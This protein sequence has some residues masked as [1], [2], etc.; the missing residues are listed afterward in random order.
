MIKN[1]R[2]NTIDIVRGIAVILMVIA[3]SLVIFNGPTIRAFDLFSKGV[4]IVA[5][6]TFLFISG[7]ATYL[8]TIKPRLSNK[9]I[10]TKYIKLIK[11]LVVYYIVAFFI[12]LYYIDTCT[13]NSIV[14]TLIRVLLFIDIPSYT[15]FLPSLFIYAFLMILLRKY[16]KLLLKNNIILAITIVL[17][18]SVGFLLYKLDTP[19]ILTYYK[20]IFV[21]H[22]DWYRFPVI[23]YIPILFL[24]S[25]WSFEITKRRAIKLKV[26]NPINLNILTITLKF[27]IFILPI[28]LLIGILNYSNM[29]TFNLFNLHRWP[30]S[31]LFLLIGITFVISIIFILESIHKYKP[32]I[33]KFISKYIGFVGKIA[34]NIYFWHIIVL[35]SYR[36]FA[37]FYNYQ[38]M[39]NVLLVIV[40]VIIVFA[41]SIGLTI[42]FNLFSK[43]LNKQ[44]KKNSKIKQVIVA[45]VILLIAI[46]LPFL[47]S[48]IT[49]FNE[50]DL[51]I[52]NNE[53]PRE[54]KDWW[55]W[56]NNYRALT[57]MSVQNDDFWKISKGDYVK[58]TLNH[59]ALV[60]QNQSHISGRD[61][62]VVYYDGLKH[63]KLDTR[64]ENANTENTSI[65]FELANSI[66]TKNIDTNYYLYYSN[67]SASDTLQ[68]NTEKPNLSN[69]AYKI[70]LNEDI[71]ASFT[72]T[73]PRKWI[74]K[75]NSI[76][77]KNKQIIININVKNIT[78]SANNIF[79]LLQSEG[80]FY[81]F[82]PIEISPEQ[83]Q[84]IVNTDLLKSG[85]Y[86]IQSN[87]SGTVY[88]TTPIMVN[89]SYPLFVT[90]TIDFEGYSLKRSY[91]DSI[92]ELSNKYQM[93][94]TQFFN[95]R[96]FIANDV[97]KS[98]RKEMID[99]VNKREKE[100]GD[101]IA[102]HLHMHYDMIRAMGLTPITAEEYSWGGRYNG[103][104]VLTSAY[105]YNQFATM[106]DWSLKKFEENGL[107]R[108]ISFRAGGWF[109]DEENIQVLEDKEFKIESSGREYIV[110]GKNKQK[111][112]WHLYSTTRPYRLME[113]DQ[114]RRGSDTNFDIFEFPNNGMDSTNNDGIVMIEKFNDNYSKNQI[115]MGPQVVTYLSHPHWF[116]TYDKRSL[117]ETFDH[118]EPMK[119]SNDKGPVVYRTLEGVYKE[120]K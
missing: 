30:P 85:K 52:T 31:I 6:S 90:W 43:N 63:I 120:W 33:F 83:Y 42:L 66:N 97:P 74:L 79:V 111:S 20:S 94:I 21:G 62:Q 9:R 46:S 5:Y 109:I 84:L 78:T 4:D 99:W 64:I 2:N 44:I 93:P 98:N 73:T 40:L 41:L 35:F 12:A 1:K 65:Y 48:N 77:E 107:S 95:P 24:G 105:N 11:M 45:V 16:I 53:I 69:K 38:A 7:A 47:R 113:S 89:V 103:H 115:M 29:P 39:N 57:E 70:F 54:T 55:W 106:I 13:F 76:E 18:Y 59:K 34:F 27:F 51:N 17:I 81:E 37:K 101:E 19:N 22:L 87:I 58:F 60:E 10:T 112:P 72:L 114:N 80:N 118:I 32:T 25:K 50:I 15:E 61:L 88:E 28:T 23:Q 104:D 67:T 110:Y 8:A 108:P 49:K 36:I 102:L 26:T 71:E 119:F 14:T 82:N 75:G 92:D 96:I 56:D 116:D 100:N 117:I 91:M 86:S 68:V 3:H